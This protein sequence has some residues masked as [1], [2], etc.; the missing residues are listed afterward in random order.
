MI[1]GCLVGNFVPVVLVDSCGS[2]LALVFMVIYYRYTSDRS[3]VHKL[4][5]IAGSGAVIVA[6]YVAIA[7]EGVTNQSRDQI[8]TILGFIAAGLDICMYS[9]PLATIRHVIATKDASSMPLAMSIAGLVNTVLW[10][11]I[12]TDDLFLAIPN[13]I[14]SGISV[15]AIILFF[16]Y[17]PGKYTTAQVE[18]VHQLSIS[19]K[20]N[21]KAGYGEVQSPVVS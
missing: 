15:V 14:A 13:G 20:S 4:W 1:Y 6:I 21:E 7:V 10:V 8:E 17:R 19:I 9:S 11:A 12:S 2:S 16:I 3:F 18:D 5:A